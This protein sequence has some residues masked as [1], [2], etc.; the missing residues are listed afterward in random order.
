MILYNNKYLLLSNYKVGFVNSGG[1]S[2]VNY[3]FFM[4][5]I[6][7]QILVFIQDEFG[8]NTIFKWTAVNN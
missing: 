7:V 4:M 5:Y 6:N 1:N 2:D 8:T 3:F